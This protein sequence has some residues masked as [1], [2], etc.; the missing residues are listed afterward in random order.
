LIIKE[1]NE[2]IEGYAES[3]NSISTIEVKRKQSYINQD[4]RNEN[5]DFKKR[6]EEVDRKFEII[7]N[8]NQL[9]REYVDEKLGQIDEVRKMVD[10]LVNEISEIRT[11]DE[12]SVSVS[13]TKNV[14]NVLASNY[15]LN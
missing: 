6:L 12:S 1:L 13:S 7:Y 8:E 11:K 4:L 10:L 3:D 14:K 15:Y 9:L 2:A 5:I